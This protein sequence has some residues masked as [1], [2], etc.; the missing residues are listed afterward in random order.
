MPRWSLLACGLP[1]ANAVFL[2]LAVESTLRNNEVSLGTVA[3]FL[4]ECTE[5][6]L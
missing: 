4:I 3:C 6:G 2:G 1:A 5:G